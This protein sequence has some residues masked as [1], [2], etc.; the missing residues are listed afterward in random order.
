MTWTEHVLP[1]VIVLG[2]GVGVANNHRDGGAGG[3]ALEQPR[4]HFQPIGFLARCRQ[5]IRSGPSPVEFV[6][7]GVQIDFDTRTYT[8]DHHAEG[9]S[10]AFAKGRNA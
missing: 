4:E 2:T 7:D 10:M 5:Q 3:F 1:G 9:R 6:L 8:V